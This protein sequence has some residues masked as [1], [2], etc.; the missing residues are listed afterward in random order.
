MCVCVALPVQDSKLLFLLCYEKLVCCISAELASLLL[1]MKSAETKKRSCNNTPQPSP[2]RQ[3]ANLV[4]RSIGTPCTLYDVVLNMHRFA[5]ASTGSGHAP[6]TLYDVVLNTHRFAA[7]STGSGHAPCT[8]CLAINKNWNDGT[9]YD[10][11]CCLS[12]SELNLP[13]F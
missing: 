5:A 4:L 2:L 8:L 3:Y 13:P 1:C 12:Q 7:A 11:I 10:N 9:N 6:C